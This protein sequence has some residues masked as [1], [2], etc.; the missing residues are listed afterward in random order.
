MSAQ[1]P[2]HSLSTAGGNVT[3]F[4][5]YVNS[6]F[7]RCPR[8]RPFAGCVKSPAGATRRVAVSRL[9]EVRLCATSIV[10]F[11]APYAIARI[12][13]W[14][15]R[16]ATPSNQEGR[17]RY[18][19]PQQCLNAYLQDLLRSVLQFDKVRIIRSSVEAYSKP[20]NTLS[21]IVQTANDRRTERQPRDRSHYRHTFNSEFVFG[22]EF[23]FADHND[24]ARSANC[25]HRENNFVVSKR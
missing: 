7:L 23:D 8:L 12:R 24:S 3:E 20:R 18:A 21:G 17:R 19:S 14:L 16:C 5:A 13:G 15:R 10:P 25:T 9:S 6:P 22:V 1:L 2:K 4:P 11:P